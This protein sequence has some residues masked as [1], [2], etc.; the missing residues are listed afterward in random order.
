MHGGPCPRRPSKTETGEQGCAIIRTARKGVGRGQGGVVSSRE[1][2]AFRKDESWS[3]SRQPVP[4]TEE[5][6]LGRQA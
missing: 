4:L 3:Q 5:G 6:V 1:G 2:P